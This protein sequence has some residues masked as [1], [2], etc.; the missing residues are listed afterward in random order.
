MKWDY[1]IEEVRF[2]IGPMADVE[3]LLNKVGSD[4]WE[5]VSALPLTVNAPG[6]VFLLLKRQKTK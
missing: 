4:G 5:A 1:R 6:A 3:A 2:G